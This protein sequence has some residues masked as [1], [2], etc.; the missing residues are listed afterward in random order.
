MWL[1]VIIGCCGWC[2][3]VCVCVPIA[4]YRGRMLQLFV[5]SCLSSLFLVSL[6]FAMVRGLLCV[7][8]SGCC[9]LV[10]VI[11][12][13]LLIVVSSCLL[14]FVDVRCYLVLCWCLLVFVGVCWCAVV[15]GGVCWCLLVFVNVR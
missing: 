1:F 2:V 15:C 12:C 10:V 5:G 4:V 11:C 6:P 9:L 3:C 8:I 13:L 7:V 14:W